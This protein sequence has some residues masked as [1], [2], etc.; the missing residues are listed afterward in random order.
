M[1]CDSKDKVDR[2]LALNRCSFGNIVLQIDK[3]IPEAG[4][5]KVLLDSEVVWITTRGI[6][7]HLRSADLF[8]QLGEVCGVF[9]EFEESPSLSSVRLKIKLKGSLPEEIPVRFGDKVLSISIEPDRVGL[10]PIRALGEDWR[11]KGKASLFSRRPSLCEPAQSSVVSSSSLSSFSDDPLSD[12]PVDA[13]P[14]AS[15]CSP[16]P[17]CPAADSDLTFEVTGIEASFPRLGSNYVGLRLD[18]LDR[19]VLVSSI[20]IEGQLPLLRFDFGSPPMGSRYSLPQWIEMGPSRIWSPRLDFRC[21]DE[22]SP[23]HSLKGSSVSPPFYCSSEERV[24]VDRS[25]IS[26][27]SADF[28]LAL[29]ASPSSPKSPE[30]LSKVFSCSDSLDS[31]IREAAILFGLEIKGSRINGEKAAIL[32]SKEAMTRNP[33]STLSNRLERE[34]RRLDVGPKTLLFGPRT[35]RSARCASSSSV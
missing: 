7:L 21:P 25:A 35:P 16:L 34:Q 4:R 30:A 27:P 28:P 22:P 20:S 26:I 11:S 6:P 31:P 2:I 18:R 14:E 33:S 9:L 19:L 32:T 1:F 13:A 5:S 12:A 24:L 17:F 23:F 8:R 3:W 10:A 15:I 29:E